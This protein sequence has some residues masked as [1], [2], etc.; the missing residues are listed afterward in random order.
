MICSVKR[1]ISVP[2]SGSGRH[3]FTLVELLVV[4]GIIAVL[5]ST[6]LPALNRAR[7]QAKATLCASN[8]RQMGMAIQGFAS[9]HGGRAPGATY[10]TGAVEWPAI[11]NR[12]WFKI[13]DGKDKRLQLSTTTGSYAPNLLSCPEIRERA[14]IRSFSMN[15]NILGQTSTSMTTVYGYDVTPPDRYFEG[16]INYYRLG[17]K[18]SKVRAPS[19]KFLI[20]ESERS[21]A[22]AGVKFPEGDTAAS[23]YVGDYT[24]HPTTPRPFWSGAYGMFSFRHGKY[25]RMNVLFVDGHIETLTPQSHLNWNDRF[26]IV[27]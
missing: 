24:N 12:E 14:S 17:A 15:I 19:E 25:S 8:M 9:E 22:S 2:V 4:I 16:A 20:L 13:K 5:I 21:T 3:G 1:L 11:V 6:L 23:W 7:A 27:P 26:R 10:T 18:L